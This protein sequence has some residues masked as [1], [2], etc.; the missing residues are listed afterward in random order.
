[1]TERS[2]VQPLQEI[3][4]YDLMKGWADALIGDADSLAFLLGR[5]PTL[6]S[7]CEATAQSPTTMS[8]NIAP[9]AIGAYTKVDYDDYGEFPADERLI[10]QLG[11]L[12]EQYVVNLNTSALGGGQS[13]YVLIQA[14]FFQDDQIRSGD[15]DGGTPRYVNLADITNPFVGQNNS[16]LPQDTVRMAL[17]K[18]TTRYG[19]PASSD[20]VAPQPN[21]DCVPLYLIHLSSDQLSISQGDIMKAG[22]GAYSGYETAPIFPGILNS[23]HGGGQ[24]EAPPINLYDEVQERL[25]NSHLMISNDDPAGGVPNIRAW[26]GDPNGHVQ[27]QTRGRVI[28]TPGGNVVVGVPDI[29][30]DYS[31][32]TN[33]KFWICT[34]S[35][36]ANGDGQAVWHL[37]VGGSGGGGGGGGGGDDDD[38]LA[39]I[40][41]YSILANLTNASAVPIG[42]QCPDDNKFLG[43][44][45]G[46]LGWFLISDASGGFGTYSTKVRIFPTSTT[47]TPTAGTQAVS[48]Q[49]I[50]GGGGGGGV[51]QGGGGGGGGCDTIANVPI[52][53]IGASATISI[54]AGGAGGAGNT[55]GTASPGGNGG[56]TTISNANFSVSSTGGRGGGGG[57]STFNGYGA[58]G[59]G[60]AGGTSSHSGTGVTATFTSKAGKPAQQNGGPND[61]GG[62]GGDTSKGSGGNGGNPGSNGGAGSLY[63][64]GG[65]GGGAVN[66]PGNGGGAS[67][68]A[69]ANGVVIVTETILT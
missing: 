69:G 9:G 59:L 8:V 42:N 2:I 16:N 23:H 24:A 51:H 19:T 38:T 30:Y 35:G 12:R 62:D 68:G 37:L 53:L 28:S 57:G 49:V 26:N 60:G 61:F 11:I 64:G 25:P 10:Y 33:P 36:I 50:G 54:G 13:Q 58:P 22:P 63:G 29:V 20:P 45:D 65:G 48:I 34:S 17:C 47:Y 67:G 66:R 27:G 3:R 56:T 4:D 15:P 31:D 55:S 32:L 21:S 40:A 18:I 41:S 6:V 5:L 44:K 1:M 46:V 14:E 7:H 43:R 52:G 39:E